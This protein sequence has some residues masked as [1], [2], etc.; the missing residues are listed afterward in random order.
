MLQ[1][2]EGGVVVTDDAGRSTSTRH[3]PTTKFCRSYALSAPPDVAFSF[4]V[5]ISPNCPSYEHKH[6]HKTCS[7]AQHEQFHSRVTIYAAH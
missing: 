4:R 3:A 2:V 5:P 1:F 6:K 7:V